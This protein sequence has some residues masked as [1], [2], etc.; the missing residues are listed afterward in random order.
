[1]KASA[2]WPP[3]WLRWG[4]LAILL[5]IGGYLRGAGWAHNPIE[6]DQ[7]IL[8]SIAMRFVNRGWEAFPLAANKSSAGIMNPPLIEYLYL[9]PLLV[10]PSLKL[11]H[12]FQAG[13]SLAAV[14][15]L[16]LYSAPLFG[17][18]VAFLAALFMAASPWAVYYGRFIW[19]PNP[20]P[21]FSTLALLAL[22]AALAHGRSPTHLSV[23][24]LGL[25]AVTQLHLSGLV[26]IPVFGLSLWLFWPHW[27]R[28][29]SQRGWGSLGMGILLAFLLYLPFLLFQ[30]GVGFQDVQAVLGALQGGTENVR[31]AQTNAASLLLN[32]DLAS[33][34]GYI[35]AVGLAGQVGGW[36][37]PLTLAMRTL[38][39]VAFA[40]ALLRPLVAM[41]HGRCWPHALPARE[42]SYLI[43]A[44][45]MSVPILLYVRHTVYL[46]NYYFLYLYPAP[47]I[48]LALMLEEGWQW[49]RPRQPVLAS[50]CA[51]L[52]LALPL[53]QFALSTQ[54]LDALQMGQGHPA[55]TAAQ[56]AEAITAAQQALHNHSTCDLIIVAEGGAI[57]SSTFGLMED[58]LYPTPV[59][60]L[61]G[62]RGYIVPAQ[63]AIYLNAVGDELVASWLAEAGTAIPDVPLATPFYYVAGQGATAATTP[64]STGKMALP[65]SATT[66]R[67]RL[68]PP[69][70]CG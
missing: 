51:L 2:Y 36:A 59:R 18:P 44:L 25:A 65:C 42:R 27:L 11:L 41:W 61:D 46:Q 23:A 63:C 28:P 64:S 12:W 58:F 10:Q 38:T 54:R 21:L 26:L 7:S 48:A 52:V 40:F 34:H 49:L 22:L 8:I 55:R 43:L 30:K 16:Y 24:L 32:W 4:G 47:F 15:L 20:I 60:L 14:L 9:L 19:N 67:A 62:G 33:G 70:R 37:R 29:S 39:A 31:E 50:A 5:A 17:R 1:M 66:A 35:E 6:G 53:G 69:N 45:W 57:E 68:P 3:R 56:M 13:L